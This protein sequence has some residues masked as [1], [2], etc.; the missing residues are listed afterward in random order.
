VAVGTYRRGGRDPSAASGRRG[1]R[2]HRMTRPLAAP[3]LLGGRTGEE[4]G[5]VVAPFPQG[6]RSTD[7]GLADQVILIV[8]PS[9]VDLARVRRVS[10]RVPRG[11]RGLST[12]R[13]RGCF[14]RLPDGSKG[15]RVWGRWHHTGNPCVPAPPVP[16]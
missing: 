5:R 15:R 2:V 14:A 6:A 11:G 8:G 9:A 10:V 13:G 3:G 16:P 4:V 1:G 12:A 7:E